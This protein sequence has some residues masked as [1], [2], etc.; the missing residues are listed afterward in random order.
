[1]VKEVSTE[2]SLL[3]IIQKEYEDNIKKDIISKMKSAI[4][5]AKRDKKE[6]FIKKVENAIT[7]D[8]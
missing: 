8:K 4:K 1:M 5:I 7:N 3:D 6:F 2:T